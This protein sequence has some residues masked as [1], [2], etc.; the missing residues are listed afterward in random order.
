MQSFGAKLRDD[1]RALP[2]RVLGHDW[3]E[4]V[5]MPKGWKTCG[6]CPADLPPEWWNNQPEFIKFR[7]PPINW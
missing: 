2:C 1:L 7:R 4:S 3:Q 5:K 6:R